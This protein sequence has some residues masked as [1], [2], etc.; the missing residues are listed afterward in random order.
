MYYNV[1]ICKKAGLLDASG[2]LKPL[3]GPADMIDA[4]ERAQQVTGAYGLSLVVQD[5][6][7]W[8]LF[9]ALY[10]QLGGDV[11]SADGKSYVVNEAHAEQALNFMTN[12][13][14]KSKVANPN[15]DYP[16]SVALFSSGKAGFLWTGEWEFTACQH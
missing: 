3:Q 1:D 15:I 9:N 7:A 2:N 8:R 14:L 4:F 10:S 16:G 12:L 13:T 6:T 5:V 11:L